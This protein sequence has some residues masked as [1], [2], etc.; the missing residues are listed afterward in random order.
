MKQ[1]KIPLRYA[2]EVLDGLSE[3]EKEAGYIKFNIP[4]PDDINSLNGEGVWGWV[5]PEDKELYD[6]DSFYGVISAILCNYPLYYGDQLG[7][8]AVVHLKCNGPN[9]PTLNPQWVRSH[10]TGWTDD[11][12]LDAAE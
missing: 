6:D 4:N 10:L 1:A 8:G 5:Y 2:L 9:R 11:D 7:Y 12:G 3:A